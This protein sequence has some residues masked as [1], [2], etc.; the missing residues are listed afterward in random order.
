MTGTL[1][2]MRN[3]S[4]RKNYPAVKTL[5]VPFKVKNMPIMANLPA[6]RDLTPHTNGVALRANDVRGTFELLAEKV[7]IWFSR[8]RGTPLGV[9]F[10]ILAGKAHNVFVILMLS[11]WLPAF[12]EGA[13]DG[14]AH[15]SVRSATKGRKSE[16]KKVKVRKRVSTRDV[17]GEPGAVEPTERRQERCGTR[18]VV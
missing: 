8:R 15:L 16:T 13:K 5:T 12:V 10:C 17:Q 11:V 1:P 2:K 7:V 3:I 4:A 14:V 9:R 18:R 6:L